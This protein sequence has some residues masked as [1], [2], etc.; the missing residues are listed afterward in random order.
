MGFL[1]ITGILLSLAAVLAYLNLKVLRLPTTIGL[2]LLALVGAGG[3]LALDRLFPGG[4]DWVDPAARL[5]GA[6]DFDETLMHGMLGFLLFAG[7]LH[8]DL[9]DLRRETWL[10]VTLATFGV[11]LTTVLVGLATWGLTAA[12]GLELPLIYCFLF[13]SL[14]APTDPIAV[15]AILKRVGAPKSIETKLAGE[16]LFNDGVGVV[17]FL[18]LMGVAGLG[19]HGGDAHG[20]GS[21]KP[22]AAVV[23]QHGSVEHHEADAAAPGVSDPGLNEDEAIEIVW[24]EVGKLFAYEAGGGLLFGLGL[25]LLA[26]LLLRWCDDYKT[27]VLITLAVVAGG[28]ALARV[29]HVSGPLAMVVAGLLVGNPGRERAMSELTA[30]RLDTFWELVDEVLNAVLF[31]LIGLEV[32][33]L[34]LN[35]KYLLA[36]AIAVPMVLLARFVAVGGAISVLRNFRQFTPHAAKVMSWAGLRGGISV[37]LALALKD[38]AHGHGDTVERAAELI[39]TMTYVVVAFSIIVQGLTVSPLLRACGLAG[40]HDPYAGT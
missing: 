25:G 15:L 2:M 9:S 32:L 26:Y 3:L 12:L 28:Y 10:V 18:A 11:V 38:A 29:L 40:Q 35:G 16:S 27:E 22:Q 23:E 21:A 8:V 6:I 13:G 5:V 1:E 14:I 33:V 20:D 34:S 36:G 31:V 37:A 19:G 39:L 7:A 4:A 24:G 30:D 17:V